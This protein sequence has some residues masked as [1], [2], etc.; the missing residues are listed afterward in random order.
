MW[1]GIAL[2]LV[3]GN[4]II[5][6]LHLGLRH[7]GYLDDGSSSIIDLFSDFNA[8]MQSLTM[9]ID[10]FDTPAVESNVSARIHDQWQETGRR[11]DSNGDW[12]D[13]GCPDCD[14]NNADLDLWYICEV[15]MIDQCSTVHSQHWCD[16][17]HRRTEWSGHT[18][19]FIED[20]K[21]FWQAS[22]DCKSRFKGNLVSVNSRAE[23]DFLTSRA[24]KQAFWLGLAKSCGSCAWTWQDGTTA[25]FQAWGEE[26][27]DGDQYPNYAFMNFWGAQ[28]I[29]D[30][31]C[32]HEWG[33]PLI[34]LIIAVGFF[35][36]WLIG[37]C[38][39]APIIAFMYKIK[40]LDKRQR[41]FPDA[42]TCATNPYG[43]GN[44]GGY[45]DFAIGLCSCCDDCGTCLHGFFLLA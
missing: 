2:Y 15:P 5:F 34:W 33:F 32:G 7:S 8:K 14:H 13:T 6:L 9:D 20:C 44:S 23:H 26:Q 31:P 3:G 25:S 16:V 27:P 37:V 40:C 21:D 4:P 45:R 12:H 41:P 43:Q 18:Y 28:E 38:I 29:D 39:I 11:L 35:L 1:G 30:Q 36:A 24:N 42:A 17:K 19:Y 22:G 10:V